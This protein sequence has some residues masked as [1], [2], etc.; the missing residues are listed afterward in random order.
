MNKPCREFSSQLGLEELTKFYEF[1]TKW[2][3]ETEF[4]FHLICI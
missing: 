2:K 4:V 3:K 1:Q